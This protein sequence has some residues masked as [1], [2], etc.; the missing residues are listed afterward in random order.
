M[1]LKIVKSAKISVKLTFIYAFM[2]TLLLL[3]LNASIL[4]GIKYYLYNQA[5]TQVDDMGRIMSK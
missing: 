3:L 2:F 4:Y 5:N 1:N